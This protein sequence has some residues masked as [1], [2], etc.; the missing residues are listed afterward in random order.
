MET[1]VRN[2]GR[3]IKVGAV[4]YKSMTVAAEKTG[5]PYMTLY[6]RVRRGWTAGQAA[7]RKVRSYTKYEDVV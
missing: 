4:T 1:K 7:N 3:R 5:I 6:M 2:K